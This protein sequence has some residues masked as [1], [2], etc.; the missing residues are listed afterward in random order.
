MLR[1]WR[2]ITKINSSP[3]NTLYYL[4]LKCFF[5]NFFIFNVFKHH[6]VNQESMRQSYDTIQR[7][8]DGLFMITVI[9]FWKKFS[10]KLSMQ[11]NG[12]IQT[13]LINLNPFFQPNV[14]F[15]NNYSFLYLIFYS[16]IFFFSHSERKCTRSVGLW[17]CI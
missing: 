6:P 17:P 2:R 13:T 7:S 8:Y 11:K 10:L 9:Q 1:F 5:W 3:Y 14:L 12:L 16:N 4:H 15:Q